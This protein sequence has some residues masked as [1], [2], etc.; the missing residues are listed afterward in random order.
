MGQGDF[1]YRRVAGWNPLVGVKVNNG[2]GLVF[3]KAGLLYLLTDH[4]ENNLIVMD[5]AVGKV[6]H[7]VN[8]GLPGAHGLTIVEDGD[9]QVLFMTCLKTSRVLKTTLE[10]E[11]LMEVGWPEESGKYKSAGEYHPSWTLHL[12]GGDF[13]VLDGYGKDYVIR[14]DKHGKYKAVFGGQEGGIRHWGPHGG[15]TDMS[16]PEKPT[17]LIAMSDQQGLAR[18][19]TEGNK[20]AEISLPSTNP[21]VI[22]PMGKH[23]LMATLGDQWPSARN[24]PGY[25]SVLD[26]DFKILS[27]IGGSAP[28]YDDKGVLQPIVA[29]G[30]FRHPHDVA[31]GPDGAL[32][33]GQFDSGDQP[34][35]KL[36]NVA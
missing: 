36:E 16:E 33:V 24:R 1:R 28:V 11:V 25:L 12:P 22:E 4:A 30:T 9:R 32:Y 13:L 2:H 5:P 6:L 23:W 17:L 26:K 29:D 35:L 8:L 18:W 21:R 20:L 27:N 7:Q 15:I 14:Y 19:S 34:L 3:D 10:G 31:I